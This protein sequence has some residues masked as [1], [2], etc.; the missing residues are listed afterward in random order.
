M[1]LYLLVLLLSIN[2]SFYFMSMLIMY[3]VHTLFINLYVNY[4]VSSAIHNTSYSII[5]LLYYL[6]QLYDTLLH[7]YFN[8]FENFHNLTYN[9][10]F[11]QLCLLIKIS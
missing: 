8:V 7:F 2:Y 10:L 9:N 11:E 4:I 3:V 5:V 6:F 1:M